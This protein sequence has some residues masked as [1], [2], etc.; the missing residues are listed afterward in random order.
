[1][2]FFEV[3]SCGKCTP[4]RI[5]TRQS[6]ETLDRIISNA[7]LRGDFELL[8]T[9]SNILEQG[10]FCGLG[11]FAAMPLKSAMKHFPEAFKAGGERK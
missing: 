11:Q 2:F 5:G 4:C 9:F 1:M 10:S 7:G 8:N 6:R 3:E